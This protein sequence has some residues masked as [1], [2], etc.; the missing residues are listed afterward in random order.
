LKTKEIGKMFKL[1]FVCYCDFESIL[2][3]DS[4]S[5]SEKTQRIQKHKASGYALIAIKNDNEIFYKNH[6]RGEDC[7]KV[8]IKDL[9]LLNMRIQAILSLIKPI[10]DL[11]DI[12]SIEYESASRCYLCKEKFDNKLTMKTKCRDH[13]HLTGKFRGP[14]HLDCNILYRDQHK[15]PIFF[16]N[17]K[18]YDSHFII[19]SLSDEDFKKCSIIPQSLEKFI[20]FSIDRIQVL[21]SYQFLSESLA[22]L[23]ENLFNSGYDFPITQKAF[24]RI[25]ENN[26]EKIKLLLQKSFYPYNYM[27]SFD[28]FN[29]KELP[30]R[31]CF[32]SDLTLSN[33]TKTD[34]KFAQKIWES[35]NIKSLGMYHDFYVQLDTAL[36]SDIFQAFRKKTFEVYRL[37][38]GHFFSIPGLA[39]S[40]SLF[41]TRNQIELLEDIDMYQYIEKGI[42]GG[43]SGV[44]KRKAIA[45]NRL[46]ANHNLLNSNLYLCHFDVNNLYGWAMNQYLPTS[47]FE[48]IDIDILKNI[49]WKSIDTESDFGFILEVD[50]AY[51]IELHDLH[52]DFPLAPEKRKINHKELS[53]YQ[54]ATLKHLTK[55]GYRHTATEKLMLTLYDK[56]NYIIHFK[57]LKLYLELGLK[58]KC[59]HRGLKFRQSKLLKPY[60][61]MNTKLRKESNNDFEK[62]LYK[63]MNNSVFGKS[64]QDNRKHLNVV[65]AVNQKQ[66]VNAVKKPTFE[67][68][69][70]IG[71]NKAIIKMKKNSVKLDKP[72]FIGFTV[73]E[74]AKYWMYTLHYKLFKKYYEDKLE[75]IYT[76]TD[77]FVYAIQTDNFEEE[78]SFVFKDIMDFSNF[79]VKH[80]LYNEHNK[81]KVGY[82]K[83]EYGEKPVNEFVGLK[84][85]LYSIMYDDDKN[86]STAKGLQKSVLKKHV[87]HQHYCDV[88]NKNNV[89]TTSMTRIQSK[90]HQLETVKL[91]KT[92]FTAFDDKRYILDDGIN[93]LPFGHKT[94]NTS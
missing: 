92:I 31:K 45:N 32:Y 65:L 78:L 44:M 59:I 36:L 46:I 43:V 83:S 10:D 57:N 81:K 90:D 40:A 21:D 1:P 94:I 70:I 80:A 17:L 55:F 53:P 8:F 47:E 5:R 24:K 48:W 72:I 58:L 51:P 56:N 66:V 12:E 61:K 9:R 19:E 29:E 75:L 52:K 42:R 11:T 35:F 93:T 38:P 63:L 69:N 34:Y 15:L 20:S 79:D 82:L 18:N 62:D 64:I 16:H 7:L 67:Q 13:D 50:L 2:I 73:L 41:Y 86:K 87:K 25:T 85:K 89:Y 77:S 91:D 60:I 76:D 74:L 26:P 3:K 6:Y 84:S 14:A 22:K 30:P 71:E 88:I 39:W 33:I 68:F 4:V 49:N 23:T 37:D 54:I 27:D 28:K